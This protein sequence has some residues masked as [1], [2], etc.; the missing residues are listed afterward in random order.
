M[1]NYEL[2]AAHI[3]IELPTAGE[4]HTCKP[5]AFLANLTEREGAVENTSFWGVHMIVMR[6][7]HVLQTGVFHFDQFKTVSLDEQKLEYRHAASQD[8]ALEPFIHHCQISMAVNQLSRVRLT[9]IT[10]VSTQMP[11]EARVS[12]AASDENSE[13]ELHFALGH[14]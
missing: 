8:H 10:S 14:Q 13:A 12:T 9:N 3:D 5:H 1:R 4:L 11:I 2:M 6:S 7:K